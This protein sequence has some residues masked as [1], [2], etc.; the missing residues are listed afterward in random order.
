[1]LDERTEF[2]SKANRPRLAG[3]NRLG[4]TIALLKNKFY[5]IF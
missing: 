4:N 5:S 3:G 2:E 1:M